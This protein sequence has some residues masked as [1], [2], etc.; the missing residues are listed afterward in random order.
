M[1]PRIVQLAGRA[2]LAAALAG[3]LADCG[4]PAANATEAVTQFYA[5]LDAA[6]VHRVPDAAQLTALTPYLADSLAHALDRARAMRESA[7]TSAP[8]EK[9][10]FADGDIF[11][12]LFEGRTASVVKDSVARGDTTLVVVQFTNDTQ[13]PPVEWKDT[14]VVVNQGGRFRLADIRYGTAWE[15]GFRGRLLDL[16]TTP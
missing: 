3:S 9:P 10:P 15:F 2:V 8:G 14:V 6:G 7:E 4:R 11:S 1:S 16:L 13:K 5:V 12:S